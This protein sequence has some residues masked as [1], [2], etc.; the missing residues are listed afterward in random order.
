[1]KI[2]PQFLSG[3]S[4]YYE[5]VS[6]TSSIHLFGDEHEGLRNVCKP[7]KKPDCLDVLELIDAMIEDHP[8]DRHIILSEFWPASTKFLFFFK[9]FR[10][11]NIL[12]QKRTFR[13]FI[14]KRYKADVRVF[15]V[16]WRTS[17]FFGPISRIWQAINYETGFTTK[18]KQEFIRYLEMC[19]QLN[20]ID[21]SAYLHDLITQSR[22]KSALMR[23]KIQKIVDKTAADREFDIS[24]S[25]FLNS[26]YQYFSDSSKKIFER[27]WKKQ[28]RDLKEAQRQMREILPDSGLRKLSVSLPIPFTETQIKKSFNL[29][30]QIYSSLIEMNIVV[31]VLFF[32]S[33]RRPQSKVHFYITTGDLHTLNLLK[34]FQANLPFDTV[35]SQNRVIHR[36]N[37]QA[38]RC[39]RLM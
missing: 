7:C 11:M 23:K 13:D 1:M 29:V 17:P 25:S 30:T 22:N 6:G 18:D 10:K 16:D 28:S 5:L 9:K 27:I 39:I 31:I 37:G 3:P 12:G 14:E 21:F 8:T 24:D 34:I 20:A 19:Q 36:Q 2:E 38:H 32:L 4:S 26:Y 15:D 35:F 33:I